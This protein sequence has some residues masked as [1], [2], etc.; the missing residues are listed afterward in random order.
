MVP[1]SA[2]ELGEL[3][4]GTLRSI[5]EAQQRLDDDAQARTQAWLDQGGDDLVPP[6]LWYTC[7]T[8]SIEVELSATVV[9]ERR[10]ESEPPT[11]RLVC[12][13][14][15]PVAVSLYGYQA[16][17]GL[18]VRLLLDAAPRGEVGS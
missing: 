17:S 11:A 16:S 12:R 18:R 3:L 13:P 6:P 14:L 15:D 9:H 4:G 8:V 1:A 7:R 2:A 10:T 5:V